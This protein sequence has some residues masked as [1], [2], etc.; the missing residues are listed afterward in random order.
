MQSSESLCSIGEWCNG[1]T[2]D[3]DSYCLGSNPSSP[4]LPPLS[5]GLGRRPLK[6][7]TWVRIPSGVPINADLKRS[8]LFFCVLAATENQAGVAF[9]LR[10][11]KSGFGLTPPAPLSPPRR[12]EGENLLLRHPH[13]PTPSPS[14][15]KGSVR[16]SASP[17]V[18]DAT[19]RAHNEQL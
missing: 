13:P 3:S 9:R 12:E 18:R 14:R 17:V 16:S 4:A 10:G 2:C 7:K 1:S 5:R 15:A 19:L 6:A 11:N 8:A